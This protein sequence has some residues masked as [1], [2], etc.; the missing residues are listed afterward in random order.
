MSSN[1]VARP[2]TGKGIASK[3]IYSEFSGKHLLSPVQFF[4]EPD[5][6]G[7]SRGG[8]VSTLPEAVWAEY[9]LAYINATKGMQVTA[10]PSRSNRPSLA[11]T[12][13]SAARS[14]GTN[15]RSMESVI[16]LVDKF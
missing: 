15:A 8:G 11:A 3:S 2:S 12:N 4:L 13:F 16:I 10:S 14:L 7:Y 5:L 9:L 1:P 6:A